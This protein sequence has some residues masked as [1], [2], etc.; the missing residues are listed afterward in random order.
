MFSNFPSEIAGGNSPPPELKTALVEQGPGQRDA[1]H[2]GLPLD[3]KIDPLEDAQLPQGVALVLV[4]VL[5]NSSRSR[6]VNGSKRS[7]KQSGVG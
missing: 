1:V 4:V 6:S 3:A 7:K 5:K 2:A